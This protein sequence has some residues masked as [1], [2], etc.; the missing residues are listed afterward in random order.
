MTFGKVLSLQFLRELK[1]ISDL[2]QRSSWLNCGLSEQM[3]VLS[4]FL[5]MQEV[6]MNVLT[7]MGQQ[8]SGRMCS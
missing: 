6:K 3:M 2:E 7:E 8:M 1:I 5:K 4:F